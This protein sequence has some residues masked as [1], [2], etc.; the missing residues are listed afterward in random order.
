[1]EFKQTDCT[2]LFE[3]IFAAIS[4]ILK[5]KSS[6]PQVYSEAF[7]KSFSICISLR[8]TCMRANLQ[9]INVCKDLHTFIVRWLNR[10]SRK[11]M[12]MQYV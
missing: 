10:I 7:S 5:E 2:F 4:C 6:L 1:M 12:S 3:I 8:W 11:N 9:T